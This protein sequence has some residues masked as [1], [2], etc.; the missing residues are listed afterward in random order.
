MPWIEVVD[1]GSA[2]G[3]LARVYRRVRDERGNVANIHKVQSLNPEAMDRHL[4]LYMTLMFGRSPLSRAERELVA[5]GVS[6]YN[7]C[8]YCDKHHEEALSRYSVEITSE[9]RE[10]MLG[11]AEKLT[12]RPWMVSKEDV[13]GLRA[14]GFNDREILDLVLVVSYF[15]FVNRLV[16]GLGVE[17]EDEGEREYKY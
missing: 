13:D 7:G 16:L 12:G 3:E 14:V 4:S 15:N 8:G 2:E 10:A 6:R 9:R 11:F 17:L 1:E 5:T